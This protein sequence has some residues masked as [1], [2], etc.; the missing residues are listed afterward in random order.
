MLILE[1]CQSYISVLTVRLGGSVARRVGR[2]GPVTLRGLSAHHQLGKATRTFALMLFVFMCSFF[3]GVGAMTSMSDDQ[4]SEVTGQALMQMGKQDSLDDPTLTFYKAGLDAEV[5]LNMNIEKLQLGCGGINGPG[6]DIDIDK[7]SLSGAESTWGVDGRPASAAILT[8]PFFEFAIRNDQSKTLREVVGI[9]L[10][11][12]NAEG[13][14]T[15]GDQQAGAGDPGNTSGI[16]SLSGYMKLGATSGLAQVATRPMASFDYTCQSGDPCEG[17]YTALGR[18]MEGRIR[19]T[20]TVILDGTQDFTAEEYLLQVWSDDPAVVN[21]PSTTVSG[22][23]MDSVDLMGTATMGLLEFAGNMTADIG[24]ALDKN[25]TG[26]I[27]GLS[28][29]V[30]IKQS[31]K[32]IHKINVNSPFSLSMQNANV[33]WPGATEEAQTGWWLAIEDTIDIGSVSPEDKVQVTNDVLLQALGPTAISWT[34]NP[35]P[36]GQS[37][38]CVQG[39]SINCALHTA[40]SAA[41]YTETNNNVTYTYHHVYGTECDGLGG[42]LGDLNVGT[43]FVPA[44]LNLPLNDLKLSGQAVTPNCYGTARFC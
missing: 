14:M 18:N 22:K 28:A 25:V 34:P 9:R 32:F 26:A 43:L 24:I 37:P 5:E 2:S 33:L 8:R 16:N 10:S 36:Q 30:P 31:L 11:A 44:V 38:T 27:G 12:E 23:R 42:C 19:I 1:Y 15:F 4:L 35:V 41:T 40:I 29:T 17:S 13:M 7:V 39:P 6:C 21:V 20:G 3:S